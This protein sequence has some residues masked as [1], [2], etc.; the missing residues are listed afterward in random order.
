MLSAESLKERDEA[1]AAW[2]ANWWREDWSWPGLARKPWIGW[3]IVAR[4]GGEFAVEADTG[5]IYGQADPAAQ[6][7]VEGRSAT[8][9]D[10]WRA[11]PET[12]RLRDPMAMLHQ[13]EIVTVEISRAQA[14]AL[15]RD[16]TFHIV[17]LPPERHNGEVTE[18]K[19]MRGNNLDQIIEL[20]T[21]VADISKWRESMTP[22]QLDGADRR[23]QF[24]G[25]IFRRLSLSSD[26]EPRKLHI[27]LDQAAI[28]DEVDFTRSHFGSGSRFTSAAFLAKAK[29]VGCRFLGDVSFWR[30]VFSDQAVFLHSRFSESGDFAQAKFFDHANFRDCELGRNAIFFNCKFHSDTDVIV[31]CSTLNISQCTFYGNAVFSQTV[32]TSAL[33][34]DGA[35]FRSNAEFMNLDVTRSV[36]FSECKFGGPTHFDNSHFGGDATFNSAQ[37]E[38]AASFFT[39]IFS[40]VVSFAFSRFDDE[41]LFSHSVF[42]SGAAFSS[43]IFSKLSEWIDTSFENS[44]DFSN[45]LFGREVTFSWSTFTSR[46]IFGYA[47]FQGSCDFGG[48]GWPD[49][50]HK[51]CNAFQH[52][53]FAF[54]VNFRG[55]GFGHFSAFNGALIKAGID[56]DFAGETNAKKVF[57]NELG[58]I[59][60]P[61]PQDVVSATDA[62]NAHRT[63]RAISLQPD[64]SMSMKAQEWLS[65]RLEEK[66]LPPVAGDS[67]SEIS[68]ARA[69]RDLEGGCRALRRAMTDA[70]DATMRQMFH[71]FELR[72]RR[73]SGDISLLERAGS[74]LYGALSNYGMSIGR[75]LVAAVF[76]TCVMASVW[77]GVAVWFGWWPDTEGGWFDAMILSLNHSMEAGVKPLTVLLSGAKKANSFELALTVLENRWESLLVRGL[78]ILQSAFTLALFFLTGLAVKRRFQMT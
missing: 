14:K 68:R 42:S 23:A 44:A 45:S 69:I 48:I 19:R 2:W 8:L 59:S 61:A 1:I 38:K 58:A 56:L 73:A 20:R 16:T 72:A 10:Y 9:Q 36:G 55:S 29:F 12:G 52:A 65:N 60:V 54:P 62:A 64:R 13:N 27:L 76:C 21:R 39:V 33:E 17:H 40:G 75:P 49:S 78:T 18:K 51:W 47:H 57:S 70:S 25:G 24:Q 34:S 74:W 41:S 67:R 43:S 11:D 71:G 3:V 22:H 28:I 5:R 31:R 7:P 30:S 37:F 32:V 46:M 15:T 77:L 35:H 66:E 4:D 50:P 26:Q 63:L 53:T 6:L